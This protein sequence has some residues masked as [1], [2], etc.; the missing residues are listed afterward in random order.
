MTIMEDME[1]H[2][3]NILE[4]GAPSID[5][6]G[7]SSKEYNR[8]TD[9]EIQDRVDEC[10]QLRYHNPDRPILQREWVEHCKGKYGDKSVPQYINYW[11]KAK[12]EYEEVWK[13]K[14]EGL[15]EPAI[16]ELREG[17]NSDNHYVKSKTIDQIFKYS[18]NDVQ[19]HLVAVQNIS[20]GFQED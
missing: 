1:N 5:S 13:G 12:S 6:T 16:Q 4:D 3:E 8:L 11:M 9:I 19:R 10:I 17:L 2:K 20:V 14:L 15:I 7:E 18:G